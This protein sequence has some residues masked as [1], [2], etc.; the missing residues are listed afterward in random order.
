MTPTTLRTLKTPRTPRTPRFLT[1]PGASPSMIKEE[2]FLVVATAFYAT[3]MAF[4]LV[5]YPFFRAMFDYQLPSRDHL[6]GHLLDKVYTRERAA[7]IDQLKAVKHVAIVTDGWSNPRNQSIINYMISSPEIQPNFWKSVATGD[8][9]HTSQYI[10]DQIVETIEEIE[11]ITGYNSVTAVVTDNARNMKA[12]WTYLQ[13]RQADVICNGCAAH[14][15]NLLIKDIFDL[16]FC[17]KVLADAKVM[18]KFVN[19]RHALLDRFR[20]M[21]TQ[22]KPK[23]ERRRA[24]ALPV[25][26]RWYT[27]EACIRSVVSNKDVLAAAFSDQSLM[28]R[29]SGWRDKLESVVA[30]LNKQEFWKN[31]EIVLRLIQPVNNALAAFESDDSCMS[32]IF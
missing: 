28:R 8:A 6:A 30:I 1:P 9:A 5:E 20:S 3:G 23:G 18:A 32:I 21:Q 2:R 4:R 31:A 16:E 19:K 26:T 27:S 17:S 10:A 13:Q 29:F 25:P 14:T 12:A 15:M 22:L 11:Q 24:L 7:V